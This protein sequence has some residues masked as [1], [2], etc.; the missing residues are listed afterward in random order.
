MHSCTG[1]SP[2]D[3][4]KPLPQKHR[5]L[6]IGLALASG[7]VLIGGIIALGVTLSSHNDSG[8]SDWGTL[9]VTQR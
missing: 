7:A 2:S 3:R 9:V 8:Y 6:R 4:P 5:G 1:P